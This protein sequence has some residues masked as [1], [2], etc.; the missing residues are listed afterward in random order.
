MEDNKDII[1]NKPSSFLGIFTDELDE[2]KVDR[3]KIPR[4][5]RDYAQGRRTEKINRI[6]NRFLNVLYEA[7]INDTRSQKL[8]FIYGSV[9]NGEL[10]PL[11]G[12]Q[13]LTTLFLLHWYVAVNEG[14]DVE[15]LASKFTYDTRFSSRDFCKELTLIYK[16][17][18]NDE[19][20]L[21]KDIIDQ[22]W[23]KLAW[24]NDPTIEAMLVMLDAIHKKFSGTSRL[25]AKLSDTENPAISFYFLPIENLGQT[26]SLYV[27]MN[28]RGKPLTEFE[29]FKAHFEKLIG[30]VSEGLR[31]DFS[32]KIDNEWT[33]LLW[34]Y[35]G[36]NNIIDDEFMR[37]YRYITDMICYER[38]GAD[39]TKTN[40]E[41]E[42]AEQV[43]GR[44]N[45]DAE[46]NI[47]TLFN[48]FD[49]W[50]AIK[51]DKGSLVADLFA[52]LFSGHKYISGK[53]KI[54]DDTHWDI[55]KKCCENYE[56][57]RN[58]GFTLPDSLLLYAV[59]MF[60]QDYDALLPN[61]SER[62][63]I[64]RN[65]I[66]RSAGDEIREGRMK[67]LMEETK[68]I[69]TEGRIDVEKLGYSKLQKQEELEKIKWRKGKDAGLIDELNHLED[70]ILLQGTVRI[71]N[72]EEVKEFS[73][74]SETFR[75]IFDSQSY[76]SNNID[77]VT[78][79]RALLSVGNYSQYFRWRTFLGGKNNSSWQEMFVMS[80]SRN[81]YE[82][83]KDCL[84][85]LLDI[86]TIENPMPE[87]LNV[88][89]HDFL[90]NDRTNKDWR[91][92]L[93]KYPSMRSGNSGVYY[94]PS[95]DGEIKQYELIMMNTAHSL[96]GYNW[97]P[98]L[99]QLKN[100]SELSAFLSLENY[101]SPITFR[102]GD[103]LTCR[104][105]HW[106]ITM[107]DEIV[108]VI[109]IAQSEGIDIEDRVQKIKKYIL[110][111]YIH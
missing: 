98:F 2:Y 97:N 58:R 63:R 101:G 42:L 83:T 81:N 82:T 51:K 92:Y 111:N 105:D 36:D 49:C 19:L 107:G 69:I 72:I 37:Y 80:G 102:N 18:L 91:Y 60:V 1:V 74:R 6:R 38:Y 43:Y 33:D 68:A 4:I 89:I 20:I 93:V 56:V 10:I 100:D 106:E 30:E 54:Y 9:K 53:V 44:E 70:H 77:Y 96:N 25:W 55:F 45:Q 99:Y 52:S 75:R 94:W 66:W 95:W 67:V 16:P 3:I 39:W 41:F 40:D 78:I 76:E 87:Q 65:L 8:D 71:I 86:I 29:H 26:D 110:E 13:R 57:G 14:V 28:S 109:D 17:N 61:I 47:K 7:L 24:R 31:S 11:D 79:S 15:V 23:F 64:I 59:L 62:I 88:I 34:P 5:Q 50:L 46:A 104:Q 21:S 103:S 32:Y 73:R 12:Q 90:N 27:K 35:R 84:E 108:K 48:A 22:P 85:T